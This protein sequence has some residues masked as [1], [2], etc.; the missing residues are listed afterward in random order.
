MIVPAFQMKMHRFENSPLSM[1]ILAISRFGFLVKVLTLRI[2]G[3]RRPCRVDLDIT[4][5]PVSGQLGWMPMV[6]IA[7]CRSVNSALR[8]ITLRNSS[9]RRIRWS[10]GVTIIVASGLTLEPPCGVG[11]AGAVLRQPVRRV[12]DALSARQV[13]EYCGCRCIGRHRKFSGGMI[14]AKRS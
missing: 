1:K 8:N 5:S 4:V 7:C 6:I 3:R 11:D 10:A 13:F 9:S 12:P 14:L 2:A